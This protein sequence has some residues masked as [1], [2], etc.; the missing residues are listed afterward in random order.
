VVSAIYRFTTQGRCR[1]CGKLGQIRGGYVF[2]SY[3]LLQA[4]LWALDD[5]LTQ[6]EREPFLVAA[7]GE[8]F[9]DA[10]KVR[11]EVAIAEPVQECQCYV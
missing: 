9:F 6:G 8:I 5:L 1:K 7:G 10:A 11:A 2:G 3:T 4:L